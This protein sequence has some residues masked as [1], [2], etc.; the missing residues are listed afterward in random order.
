MADQSTISPELI[1][2]LNE[3]GR[4][5]ALLA[6]AVGGEVPVGSVYSP[7]AG[8]AVY[9]QLQGMI[10]GMDQEVPM[11]IIDGRYEAAAQLLAEKLAAD[12]PSLGFTVDQYSEAILQAGKNI[13]NLNEAFVNGV[14]VAATPTGIRVVSPD[15]LAQLQQQDQQPQTQTA[16][17]EVR[18]EPA[19]EVSE[20]IRNC[21]KNIS[22][23]LADVD[24]AVGLSPP[25]E[26]ALEDGIADQAFIDNCN[27]LL[28]N[29]MKEAGLEKMF[30]GSFTPEF[31]AQLSDNL[32]A[33]VLVLQG[34]KAFSAPDE[35]TK[36]D[37]QINFIR[38]QAPDLIRDL[39]TLGT[40]TLPDG[41]SAFSAVKIQEIVVPNTPEQGSSIDPPPADPPP[42]DPPPADPPPADVDETE[43]EKPAVVVKTDAEKLA[44]TKVSEINGAVIAVE[45]GL[46]LLSNVKDLPVLDKLGKFGID[47]DE[48]IDDFLKPINTS[49]A[50]GDGQKIFDENS[51]TT[52]ATMIMMLK[53]VGGDPEADG[54]YN[55]TIGDNLQV[56]ILS[57]PSYQF[58]RDELKIQ[59]DYTAEEAKALMVGFQPSEEYV[60]LAS[61]TDAEKEAHK[62]AYDQKIKAE[63]D[64]SIFGRLQGDNEEL[65][66]VVYLDTM[67]K[68]LDTLSQERILD[69]ERK[70]KEQ[71][72]NNMMV[73]VLAQG[74]EKFG[75]LEMVTDFLKSEWGQMLVDVLAFIGIDLSPLLGE[76]ARDL[77][78]KGQLAADISDNFEEA[79]NKVVADNPNVT[80]FD[81]QMELTEKA[82]LENM[83]GFVARNISKALLGQDDAA[84]VRQGIADA[85]SAARGTDNIADARNAFKGV[86]VEFTQKIEEGRD[87][88]ARSEATVDPDS[89]VDYI[90]AM[91]AEGGFTAVDN[92][93]A[94]N[95]PAQGG[96]DQVLDF[97]A[98]MAPALNDMF[99]QMLNENNGDISVVREKLVNDFEG[100][101]RFASMP[102]PF[103]SEFMQAV[104]LDAVDQAS[105][106]D[107][108][109]KMAEAFSSTL[110]GNMDAYLGGEAVNIG[111]QDFKLD[112]ALNEDDL[113]NLLSHVTGMSF[114]AE[115]DV[116]DNA[117]E[118]SEGVVAE[119]IHT[120]DTT[121]YIDD[122]RFIYDRDIPIAE[123]LAR[124][125][126]ALGLKDTIVEGVGENIDPDNRIR[127]MTRDVCAGLEELYMRA[128]IH[129]LFEINGENVTLD[130][131]L[132]LDT[133]IK[134]ETYIES[135]SLIEAYISSRD[136]IDPQRAM[137]FNEALV[138][139]GEDYGSA[140]VSPEIRENTVLD[141]S[142]VWNQ[143]DLQGLLVQMQKEADIP[144]VIVQEPEPV[145]EKI[146]EPVAVEPEPKEEPCPDDCKIVLEREDNKPPG[147]FPQAF[148]DLTVIKLG[149][150]EA[151][152]SPDS[153]ALRELVTGDGKGQMDLSEG[154]NGW[155]PL[156]DLVSANIVPN[157]YL[158][159]DFETM[160]LERPEGFE[161]D[162]IV[163][164]QAVG[165]AIEYHGINYEDDEIKSLAEHSV[166]FD[167]D[168]ATRNVLAEKLH[169]FRDRDGELNVDALNRFY[170]EEARPGFQSNKDLFRNDDLSKV[171]S[172]DNFDE[173][174]VMNLLEDNPRRLEW[175]VAEL[176]R[177][178]QRVYG[179]QGG[180]APNPVAGF[181]NLRIMQRDD[182]GRIS[183]SQGLNGVYDDLE[184]GDARIKFD[185]QSNDFYGQLMKLEMH[186]KNGN[187]LR[188]T[189][190]KTAQVDTNGLN[191]AFNKQNMDVASNDALIEGNMSSIGANGD[192]FDDAIGGFTPSNNVSMSA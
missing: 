85:L 14:P 51:Q 167:K 80:D 173:R 131:V 46:S 191:G 161:F 179:A 55:K 37:A 1:N 156:K 121:D 183:V 118:V 19:V 72:Q 44:E 120:R 89:G 119:V 30:S 136:D 5:F 88:A 187:Y 15:E 155:H 61:G 24:P 83:D 102:E 108:Q 40:T 12:N 134:P 143:V 176:E 66:N 133:E 130:D 177:S 185:V 146:P 154:N 147:G 112:R 50:D 91:A 150:N 107:D 53:M 33:A 138:S 106:F 145:I 125:G 135:H 171:M 68:G 160:G 189:P 48:F 98:S 115:E 4:E 58:V 142:L 141:H 110:A 163:A 166:G 144:V 29:V 158:L 25:S 151:T 28:A 132:A 11:P 184:S 109:D 17:A 182:N 87:Y 188:I 127:F 31:G 59:G 152:E 99:T 49:D 170:H 93:P 96:P 126:A 65:K 23:I 21:V 164:Y 116:P 41:S 90:R 117:I 45:E 42:A 70:A 103:S 73:N 67:F 43:V 153:A 32:D 95:L 84:A 178:H 13:T 175:F 10:S 123:F 81:K 77:T 75:M 174:K 157:Q 38:N 101:A 20:E 8:Q 76:E 54:S 34:K 165:H 186:L 162:A 2:E 140:K 128:Q 36:I 35:K 139:L 86:V 6:V 74:L 64:Q 105:A 79:F 57:H 190:E 113:Q 180:Q 192:V 9:G 111:E 69:P 181:A 168:L 62:T 16:Q 129:Q 122:T 104:V 26:S 3:S 27:G 7:D 63:Y 56:A 169:N 22:K 137:A 172:G 78:N 114:V 60:A 39:N 148:R 94:P 97:A 52:T 159:M 82:M 100:D 124:D 18:F 92:T 149:L 47:A 71:N